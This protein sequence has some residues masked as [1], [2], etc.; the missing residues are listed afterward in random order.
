MPVQTSQADA[1]FRAE[2][3]NWL[4][5]ELGGEWG[6]LRGVGGPGREHEQFEERRAWNRHLAAAGWTCLGW[7]VEH[8][9]RDLPISQQVIFHEEYARAEAPSSVNHF[10][11][12]L[13]GPTLIAYGTPE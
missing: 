13:I 11:E 6:R 7:P 1:D 3:R 5:A 2:V 12:Q 10:G 8:G 9:G 4:E